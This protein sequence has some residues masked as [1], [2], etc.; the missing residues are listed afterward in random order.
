[1]NPFKQRT[2]SI[3]LA[4]ILVLSLQTPAARA[5]DGEV[6]YTG[7]NTNLI[8]DDNAA[9]PFGL[10]FTFQ[11]YGTNYTQTYVNIN[12][13]LNFGAGNSEYGNGTLNSSGPS[14]SI[15]AFWDDLITDPS[16]YDA[17]P[18]YYATVGTSPNR[19]FI[20][21][22]TNMYFFSTTIQMGTF[23]VILYEG[24]NEI[25]IQYRDLLGGSRALGD[26]ATIGIKK[27]NSTYKQYSANTASLT[28]GQ[29]IRYTPNGSNDYTVN[30]NATYD[31]VYLAPEGA[32]TSPTLVNPT[33]GSTGVTLA[34]TFEW[35]PVESA[36]SYTVLVST[37]SNFS[38]TVVNQSG[39]TGTSY[40][41]GSNLS[42]ST[43]Y[44]WRVQS[45]NNAGSSLSPTRSFTTG[46]VN[47]A[48]NTPTSVSSTSLIGGGA[49][50]NAAGSTLSATL[51]DPDDNESVRYRLQIASDNTFTTL[52]VDYRSPFAAE[53]ATEFTFGTNT[54]TYLVGNSS[55]TLTPGNYY[56]RIRAED[57]AAA[58][59]AWYTASGIAFR[60]ASDS[61]PPNLS[62]D[63]ATPNPTND[64]TP[65]LT[66]TATDA[67][68]T[69]ASVEFQVDA[70]NGAWSSCTA[71]DGTFDEASETFSCTPG[72][73][74]SEGN[75]TMYVR[76]TDAAN[77]TTVALDY[78]STT[79][80]ID[81]TGPVLSGLTASPEL[82]SAVITWET[83]VAASSRVAYGPTSSYGGLTAETNTAPRVTNHSVEIT[84]LIPCA[85]YHIQARSADAALNIGQSSDATFITKGCTGSAE[86][87]QTG[88]EPITS[89]A[90]GTITEGRLSLT[91]PPS[92]ATGIT[93]AVFQAHQLD[94]A[95]F[96]GA[97]GTPT[98][99]VKAGT[100]VF[101]LKALTDPTETVAEFNAPL[102]VTLSYT[103]EDI[104]GIVETSLV[105]YR[106]D[107]TA[108]HPLSNCAVNVGAK[109]VTC[110]TQGFSDFA[111]FGT[112]HSGG[113]IPPQALERPVGSGSTL[114]MDVQNGSDQ[115]VPAIT[116]LFNA[117]ADVTHVS[118]SNDS[119]F[120][121]A[122]LQD[123]A[124]SVQWNVCW[125]SALLTTPAACPD[126]TYTVYAKLYTAWG[127]PSEVLTATVHLTAGT[128]STLALPVKAHPFT[129]F[130]NG[131]TVHLIAGGTQY[132]FASEKTF[133]GLGYTYK[134]LMAKPIAT[135]AGKPA[136]LNNTS[137]AHV[138]GNWIQSG[139]TI[140]Y[141]TPS[142]RIPFATYEAFTSNGG[143]LRYVVKANA[144]DLAL[145]ELPVATPADPRLLF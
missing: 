78:A 89:T 97:A 75:H 115:T 98:G 25:Q 116:V 80:T 120:T 102:T 13:T 54:G 34:P 70:T 119:S 140:F 103:P 111:L 82:T 112:A 121:G 61:T 14:N 3:I 60:I 64:A 26:S 124:P 110:Q 91:V 139:K 142:G 47:A 83:D 63:P 22:W 35:L 62:L 52:L 101:N 33:D 106:Y 57:D 20:T 8:G 39:I 81:L 28:Q 69:V 122:V 137:A 59:S 114:R 117:G 88:A 100:T 76:T 143:Q 18:I 23:Q 135:P 130:L 132:A 133:L 74:L 104:V 134:M 5:V 42:A 105:I 93:E 90:G 71:T 49:I 109:T 99:V 127:Q 145:P 37:V 72:S 136:I 29:A 2:V 40:T 44:Y 43:T 30:T 45:V 36:T 38:S 73:A 95:A 15:Y 19:K 67:D 21:Q 131:K 94:S 1:M 32:P 123:Y 129:L 50:A 51:T 7:T 53:G 9:G 12:G 77:N 126:A 141:I 85:L 92:F 96:F 31:L 125:Q 86:V 24:T 113:G 65:T 58:S 6:T 17:H 107:G 66:G 108:W 128:T 48:P 4:C 138:P 46:S 41:L 68:G 84:N 56:L 16:P 11:Y 87:S 118:L 27:D 55:T 79:I 10:G 144:F